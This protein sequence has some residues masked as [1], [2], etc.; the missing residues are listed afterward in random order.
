MKLHLK[1]DDKFMNGL[2]KTLQETNVCKIV[3][4]AFILLYW[5]ASERKNNRII[6]SVD[7]KGNIVKQLTPINY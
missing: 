6:L 5:I 2:Q 1:V 4:D 3:D 7:K